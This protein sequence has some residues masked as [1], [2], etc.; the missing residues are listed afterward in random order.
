MQNLDASAGVG[1]AVIAYTGAAVGSSVGTAVGKNV[2]HCDGSSDGNNVG[3]LDG[4]NVWRKAEG[5][6]VGFAVGTNVGQSDGC[7]D[8]TK[9]G[10]LVGSDVGSPVGCLVG[11]SRIA[12]GSSVLTAYSTILAVVPNLGASDNSDVGWFEGRRVGA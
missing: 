8:G 10:H 2:G 1:G 5:S 6:N 11:A 4:S 7:C 9:V 12:V 3:H